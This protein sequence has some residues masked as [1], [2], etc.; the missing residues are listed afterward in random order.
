MTANPRMGGAYDAQTGGAPLTVSIN[1]Y[2]DVVA[3]MNRRFR[4]GPP[5]TRLDAVSGS[6]SR[7]ISVPSGS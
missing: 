4:L 7:P 3:V 2:T 5:N 1:E 6:L